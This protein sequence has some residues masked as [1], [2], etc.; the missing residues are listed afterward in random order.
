MLRK[1]VRRCKLIA[2]GLAARETV[3]TRFSAQAYQ[4]RLTDVYLQ[5]L[6]RGGADR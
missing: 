5:V 6:G 1:G 3:L 4:R 2:L